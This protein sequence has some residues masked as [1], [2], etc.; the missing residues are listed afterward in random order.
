MQATAR[1]LA[2]LAVVLGTAAC[3]GQ[4]VKSGPGG[5]DA[6]LDGPT[7]GPV[8]AG[9]ATD[10]PMGLYAPSC[11]DALPEAGT[12]CT[13][14]QSPVGQVLACEYGSDTRCTS[15]AYCCSSCG[16][17][18]NAVWQINDPDPSCDGNHLGWCPTNYGEPARAACGPMTTCMF[19]EGRCICNLCLTDAGVLATQMKCDPW[20]TPAGCP[21]VRPLLGTRCDVEGQECDYSAAC[22]DQVDTGPNMKCN[23]GFWYAIARDCS[24]EPPQCGAP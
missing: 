12:P 15:T 20:I 9:D 14:S 16:S 8:D 10:G 17:T 18:F 23:G 24:C 7:V 4:V 3:G 13:P 2:A 22:C 19:P 6:S 11:H 1:A 21:Q 5:S